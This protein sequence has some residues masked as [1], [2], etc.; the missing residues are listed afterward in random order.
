MSRQ[1]P[2]FA[3]YKD[4]YRNIALERSD[5]GVLLVRFHTN[6]G[7][8]VWSEESHEELGY[9]FADI[10]ADRANRVVVMDKGHIEQIGTLSNPVIA[11]PHPT[12]YAVPQRVTD[13][14]RNF[15]AT[16]K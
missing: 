10:G 16:R 9:C 14:A 6:G 12:D 13:Y 1:A 15:S 4:R 3:D 11:A 2:Q 7:A 8:F 5:D